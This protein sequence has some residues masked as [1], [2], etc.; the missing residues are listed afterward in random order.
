MEKAMKKNSIA[1]LLAILTAFGNVQVA[2]AAESFN[3][4]AYDLSSGELLFREAHYRYDADGVAQHLVL[5][6][7]PDGRAFAR[8]LA[9]DDGDAQAPAFDLVGARLNYHEG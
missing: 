8:K 5:Y 1:S 2:A 3:G 4:D 6:R 7:C 9:R